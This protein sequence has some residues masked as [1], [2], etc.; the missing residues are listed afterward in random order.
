MLRAALLLSIALIFGGCNADPRTT[1]GEAN[2]EPVRGLRTVV[3]AAPSQTTVRKFPSVLQPAE[4][5]DI[6]FEVAGRLRK[7]DLSVGQQLN[8]G[9]IIAE[10][11]ST[12]FEVEIENKN[13]A[14]DEAAAALKQARDN[15]QRKEILFKKG[16]T[17]KVSLDDARTDV[18]TKTARL[19]QARKLLRSAQEDLDKTV[20]RAPFDGIINSV[21]ADSFATLSVGA[22]VASIYSTTSFE[23]SFSVNFDTV[24]RLVVGTPAIVRLA[25]NPKVA[26][27]AAVSELGE[28]ADTVSSF[29]VIVTLKELHPMVKAG[30]A[31]EVSFEFKLP[32]RDGY[33]LP[34]TAAIKEGTIEGNAGAGNIVPIGVFVFDEATSTV[35]RRE[36]MIA[37]VQENRL[38]VVKG[39]KAGERVAR[40]GVSFLRDGMKV[41]LLTTQ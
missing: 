3:V 36:V 34:L 41:K 29:P 23:M 22:P 4:I 15:L 18:Q 20:L 30:M 17:T 13:A 7:L 28:R 40:S 39:L 9:Y 32:A 35:R 6:S 5:T 2:D 12:Q 19:T 1:A 25:D 38:L 8:K 21:N 14:V 11:D 26:L 31:V 27:K 10:L 16:A 37:G 24:R 33:P